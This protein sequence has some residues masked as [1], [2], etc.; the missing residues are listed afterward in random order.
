MDCRDLRDQRTSPMTPSS[1]AQGTLPCSV[2]VWLLA[3]ARWVIQAL[4][5]RSGAMRSASRRFFLSLAGTRSR[6][7]PPSRCSESVGG[8]G[9]RGCLRRPGR[10]P[11][12]DVGIRRP[13]CS[14]TGT[15]GSK[16]YRRSRCIETGRAIRRGSRCPTIDHRGPDSE[17]LL[18]WRPVDLQY[19]GTASHGRCYVAWDTVGRENARIWGVDR[20]RWID[21]P[22]CERGAC[23]VTYL[24][25]DHRQVCSPSSTTDQRV[26]SSIGLCNRS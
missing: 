18:R 22:W 5:R 1:Q 4:L 13:T 19:G 20:Q 8:R 23:S 26:R 14:S 21:L 16:R 6:S 15:G 9:R 12:I 7:R 11:T 24:S 17:E 3:W 25:C 2:R 10:P